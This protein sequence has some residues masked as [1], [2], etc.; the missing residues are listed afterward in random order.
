[1]GGELKMNMKEFKKRLNDNRGRS[2]KGEKVKDNN[3]FMIIDL[4]KNVAKVK[5]P[6]SLNKSEVKMLLED[7]NLSNIGKN[8]VIKVSEVCDVCYDIKCVGV[9]ENEILFVTC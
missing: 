9:K 8:S 7:L 6:L 1:M 2:L 3:D 5:S 4:E